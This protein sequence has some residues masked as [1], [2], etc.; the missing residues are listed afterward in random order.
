MQN[1]GK[2]LSREVEHWRLRGTS[3]GSPKCKTKCGE[4]SAPPRSRTRRHCAAMSLAANVEP[5]PT[6]V[7]PM[8]RPERKE[9]ERTKPPSEPRSQKPGRMMMSRFLLL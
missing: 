2:F 8:A 6:I 4:Y 7:A 5:R 9:A 1:V 3:D